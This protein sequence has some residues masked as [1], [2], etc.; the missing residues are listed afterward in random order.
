MDASARAPDWHLVEPAAAAIDP[1]YR[2]SRV[3]AAPALDQ[4]AGVPVGLKIECENPIGS[5][6]GRGVDWLMH[7]AIPPGAPVFAASAGNFGQGLAR[8]GTARG[9][10]VTV[11]AATTAN[12]A[13]LDAMRR[14]GATVVLHGADFDAA[15]AEARARAAGQGVRFVEDAAEPETWEGAGT[16]ALE[17]HAAG[18][19]PA[20]L[21]V[22]LGNGAMAGG[23]A[24]WLRHAVP[25]VR[26]VGVV[27]AGA[28]AMQL[29]FRAGRAMDTERAATI[30][31]GIGVRVSIPY[32]VHHLQPLLA[33][34]VAVADEEILAAMRALHRA[35]GIMAEPSGAAGLAAILRG[36]HAGPVGTVICGANT[37]AEQKRE[38]YGSATA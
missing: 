21:F 11:F 31:D 36:G 26:V 13:K 10:P 34:V 28:P 1:A 22:P 15:K 29:S 8:A 30:A 5:F 37:T 33:D 25:G 18:T 2:N 27:A 12:P 32:A 23:M 16:I 4:A 14:L 38:W 9:N 3:V 6:K 35:T 19:L 20:T 7:H 17:W 24:L